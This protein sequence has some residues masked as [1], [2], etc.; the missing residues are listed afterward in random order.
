MYLI[1]F[2]PVAAGEY[3]EAIE[4]YNDRDPA[5]AERF[6]AAVNNKLDRIESNPFQYKRLFRHFHEVGLRSFPYTIVYF[7]EEARKKVVIVAI[8]HQKRHPKKKYRK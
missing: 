3:E 4:W 2:R 1:T 5:V 8:Y 6:I 7:V